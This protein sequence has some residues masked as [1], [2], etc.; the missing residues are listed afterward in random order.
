MERLITILF[1]LFFLFCLF[2]S[3]SLTK[4]NVIGKWLVPQTDTLIIKPDYSFLLVKTNPQ[5]SKVQPRGIL[6]TSQILDGHWSINKKKVYFIFD[7]TT[8][9][10]GSS[11]TSLQYWWRRGSKKKLVMPRTCTSPTHHFVTVKKIE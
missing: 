9:N 10:L 5:T 8:K 3:C 1:K 4:N 6:L 2:S 11:C 7:D